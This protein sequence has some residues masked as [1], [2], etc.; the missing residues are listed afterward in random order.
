MKIVRIFGLDKFQ[1]KYNHGSFT[2]YH[3]FGETLT[4]IVTR[5]DDFGWTMKVCYN[6][7]AVDDCTV[8]CC[9]SGTY[10]KVCEKALKKVFQEWQ[11]NKINNEQ[12]HEFVSMCDDFAAIRFCQCH[13]LK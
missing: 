1:E 8:V 5:C 4:V 9:K 7:K 13:C 2:K 3:Y 12:M 11:E 6:D 10:G